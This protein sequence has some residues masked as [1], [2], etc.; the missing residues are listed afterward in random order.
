MTVAR[1]DHTATRLTDGRVLIV[2]GGS[3]TELLTSA[4]LYDPASG[5]FSPAGSM[6]DPREWHTATLLLDGRVLIAGG[7]PGR[8]TPSST[9]YLAACELYQP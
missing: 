8:D 1:S 3:S 9:G 6:A 5:K 4:E 2:G 7:D